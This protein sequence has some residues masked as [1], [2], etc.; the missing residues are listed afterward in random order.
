MGIGGS[1]PI[2]WLTYQIASRHNDKDGDIKRFRISL[3]YNIILDDEQRQ[4]L[5]SGPNKIKITRKN[6]KQIKYLLN[7]LYLIILFFLI[8]M[9]QTFFQMN[10][11]I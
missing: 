10:E 9:K 6:H 5:E 1:I 11:T 4:L 3:K 7:K 2:S 8:T